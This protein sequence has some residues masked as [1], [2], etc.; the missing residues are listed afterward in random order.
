MKTPAIAAHLK[1]TMSKIMLTVV[2][3]GLVALTF[4]GSA[5]GQ[6]P[7][8][9][10]TPTTASS[11][12][13]S[14]FHEPDPLAFDDHSGFVQIFDGSTL[15]HWDG[16]PATWRVE[17][18][19]IVGESTAEKPRNNSYISYHGEEAKDF[20]LKL[21]IKV[22]KGGGS[23]IQYRSS[24][25]RPWLRGARP[26]QPPPNLAW[27]MTGPQADFWFPVNPRSFDYTGQFYSENTSLGILAWRGQVT[28]SE[29]GKRPRLVGNIGSRDA[30]GGYIK[31]NDWN[32]YEIIAR[33]GTFIHIIN[34]QLMAV[35]IDDDPSSSNNVSGL[36]GFEVEGTP[37]KVSVRNVWLKKLK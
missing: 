30:L 9:N 10:E 13:P 19:A 16:D 34:G 31:I 7:A 3:C 18:G 36:I 37:T 4:L 32:Q 6:Q 29:P 26:G 12:A 24:V 22:E 23:G 20:D 8:Q 15:N 2:P 1:D 11:Q 21:E 28:E 17:N 14:R 5:P 27:M 35:Y 25:G 33:G